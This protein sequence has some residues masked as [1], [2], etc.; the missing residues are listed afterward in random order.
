MKRA[1]Q[2]HLGLRT[3]FGSLGFFRHTPIPF[4]QRKIHTH[5]PLHHVFQGHLMGIQFGRNQSQNPLSFTPSLCK[6]LLQAIVHFQHLRGLHIQYLARGRY[7]FHETL[8][9]PFEFC[10]HR[11]HQTLFSH[12]HI[13]FGRKTLGLPIAKNAPHH[14]SCLT[15]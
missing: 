1:P 6:Q 15:L 4:G 12:R 11:N 8:Y 5:K 10:H 9:P 7:V 14:I 3:H 13:R 2:C